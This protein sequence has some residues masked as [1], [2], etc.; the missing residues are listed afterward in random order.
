V[1]LFNIHIHEIAAVGVTYQ[2]AGL[3]FNPLLLTPFINS[4]NGPV[5]DGSQSLMGLNS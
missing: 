5:V 1:E 3:D 4:Y 2:N